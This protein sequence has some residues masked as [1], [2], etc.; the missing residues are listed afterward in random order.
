DEENLFG[1]GP[2][3]AINGKLLV[4]DDNEKK[5]GELTLFDVSPQGAT[6]IAGWKA[7]EGHDAWAPMAYSGGK[8]IL[9]DATT[10]ICL[11]LAEGNA[12]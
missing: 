11:Q 1:L 9:R 4:L 5:P 3:V 2:Y 6:R 12:I 10:L 7:I 8:L